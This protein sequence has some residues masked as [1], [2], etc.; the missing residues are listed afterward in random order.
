[1]DKKELLLVKKSKEGDTKAFEQLIKEHEQKIYNL[2]L[3]M[4]NNKAAADDFLQETFLSAWQKIKSF[5]GNSEFS[6]WLYRI[7]INHVLMKR[8]RKKVIRTVSLDTPIM[9]P[10]GEI[11]RE[12]EDDWSRNPLATLENRELKQKLNKAIESLPE[13]YRTILVLKDIDGLSNDE[14]K[15]ILS[16]SLPS[17]KSRLHRARLFL[18]DEIARY[19]K[20]S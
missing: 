11:K 2:L 19:F 6:T 14:V 17:V 4:T 8:R 18:R 10:K 5:K 7:A 15:K 16:I 3:N 1:M 12:F 13:I 9:T 20:G